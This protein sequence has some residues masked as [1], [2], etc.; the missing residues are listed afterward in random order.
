MARRTIYIRG[1]APAPELVEQLAQDSSFLEDARAV[2]DLET[3]AFESLLAALSR[4]ESFVTDDQLKSIVKASVDEGKL[5]DAAFDLVRHLNRTLRDLGDPMEKTLS[6]LRSAI[7]EHAKDIPVEDRET[8]GE[9]LEKLV[10]APSGLGLQWKAD[11]L[12]RSTG[13]EVE[14]IQLVC[15]IRPVFDEARSAIM[16]AVPVSTLKFSVLGPDSTP[17]NI[18]LRLT[19]GQLADLGS[20]AELA[21]QKIKIIKKTLNDKRIPW[22][23]TRTTDTEK[24]TG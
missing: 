3:E 12:A 8:L 18:E 6:R 10:L 23:G 20:K 13:I 22:V 4:C 19:E 2:L 17:E 7:K 16:G 11:Q 1:A 14:D 5:A 15:D 24:G 21:Q 9:R